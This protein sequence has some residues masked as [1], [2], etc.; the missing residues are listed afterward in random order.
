MLSRFL[1]L[2]RRSHVAY[3]EKNVDWKRDRFQA[4]YKKRLPFLDKIFR[5][6]HRSVSSA[7]ISQGPSLQDFGPSFILP[8]VLGLFITFFFLSN[9]IPLFSSFVPMTGL[10]NSLFELPRGND[11]ILI[12]EIMEVHEE[13]L[14]PENESVLNSPEGI[15]LQGLSTKSYTLQQGDTLSEIASKHNLRMD[16]LIA[17]N[18]IR[19]ARR[20]QVGMTIKIPNVDGV[21]Y[22]VKS[23]ESIKQIAKKFNVAFTK[24]LDI[25]DLESSTIKAGQEIFIPE[26][27]MSRF[28]L[29]K[30]MGELFLFPC[31]GR[32]T[33]Y[34]GYRI[35]PFTRRRGFH[36]GID[37]ANRMWTPVGAAMDGRILRTGYNRVYGNYVIVGH[38]QGYQ[39]W[40]AHLQKWTVRKGQ[41]VRQ[42]QRIGY[43]GNTGRSTGA[44]LHFS[45][46]HYGKPKNP[47]RYLH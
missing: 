1:H 40:Y 43:M 14:D 25:N 13:N 20:L 46:F 9:S 41:W 11:Q 21:L 37:L 30:A 45:I 22:K 4:F 3:L 18:S 33:S 19:N 39:T 12:A 42:G 28:D 15:F 31:A 29:K 10:D 34:F 24:I 17:Y 44:H 47:I 6:R 2:K 16:T 7:H 8:F 35:D 27:T 26:A 23:G 5:K 36:N 32:F 38:G